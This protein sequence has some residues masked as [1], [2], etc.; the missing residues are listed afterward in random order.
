VEDS[1]K[2]T[3]S[4]PI[5]ISVVVPVLNEE[6]SVRVLIEGLLAQTLLPHEIV[7]TDGGSVDATREIIEEFISRGAPVTLIRE[8]DSMPGRARNVGVKHAQCDWIAFTDAGIRPEPEWLA[9]LAGR[10]AT[11]RMPMSSMDPLR[12]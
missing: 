3:A 4:N 9:G 8:Q 1:V 2:P 11:D 10:R 6:G 12:R 5:E 7:I